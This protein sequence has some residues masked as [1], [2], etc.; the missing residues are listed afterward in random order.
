MGTSAGAV[1]TA[2]AGVCRNPDED[3]V[4]GCVP[5]DDIS[6][7][8]LGDIVRDEGHAK[9][10]GIEGPDDQPAYYRL[11]QNKSLFRL[12]PDGVWG[13]D[14]T[15]KDTGGIGRGLARRLFSPSNKGF[16]FLNHEF[17]VDQSGHPII[18]V[19]KLIE[20]D[21]QKQYQAALQLSGL[22]EEKR[23][24]EE[25]YVFFD[26]NGKEITPFKFYSEVARCDF[27]LSLGLNEDDAR[28]LANYLSQNDL[29]PQHMPR[30]RASGTE[31]RIYNLKTKEWKNFDLSTN[32]SSYTELTR[33]ISL[34]FRQTL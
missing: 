11:I 9:K 31:V 27:G 1:D 34:F 8:L 4:S 5:S 29:V 24:Q 26:Q 30:W 19:S 3:K 22:K 17:F 28:K 16:T 13:V 12:E 14:L 18:N 7:N 33:M 20:K 2:T 21:H 15:P 6:A 23:G 32:T 10:M 25:K